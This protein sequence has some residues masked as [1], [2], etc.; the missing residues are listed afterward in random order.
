M[1]IEAVQRKPWTLLWVPG[2]YKT[3][4]MWNEAVQRSPWVL[5]WVPA[6]LVTQEICIEAVKG[7][8]GR[9]NMF[10]ISIKL[11]KCAMKQYKGSLKS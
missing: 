9:L 7:I 6:W 10:L 2:Q 4:E 5:V 8:P 11:K 1:C 3:Q